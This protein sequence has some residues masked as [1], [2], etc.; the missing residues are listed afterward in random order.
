MEFQR[1]DCKEHSAEE[2]TF[3]SSILQICEYKI[4]DWFKRQKLINHDDG[5]R[6]FSADDTETSLRCLRNVQC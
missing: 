2:Q 3:T 6:L 4:F 1:I 5:A